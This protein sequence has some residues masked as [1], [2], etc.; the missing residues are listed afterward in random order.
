L[1]TAYLCYG[2][3]PN[4]MAQYPIILDE[5]HIFRFGSC[6]ITF[7][8]LCIVR[9]YSSDPVIV[10]YEIS[11]LLKSEKRYQRNGRTGAWMLREKHLR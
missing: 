9:L 2:A 10:E 1:A 7:I 5:D 3:I 8:A 4:V 11:Q 6:C